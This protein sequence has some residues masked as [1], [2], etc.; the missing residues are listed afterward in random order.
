[1]NITGW[2][3][4]QWPIDQPIPYIRNARTHSAE[5]IAQVA[6]KNVVLF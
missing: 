3:V 4:E 2:Q 1:M 5:Q 6:G